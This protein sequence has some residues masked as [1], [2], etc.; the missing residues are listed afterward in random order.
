MAAAARGDLATAQVLCEAGAAINDVDVCA[1]NALFVAA[2]AME[3][4][5]E[6]ERAQHVEVLQYLYK[7]GADPWQETLDGRMAVVPMLRCLHADSHLLQDI[8]SRRDL[9]KM[10]QQHKTLLMLA[11]E[12]GSCA[13]VSSLIARGAD[14]TVASTSLVGYTA[15]H[16]A[17]QSGNVSVV[18]AL[19]AECG[20]ALDVAC[21]EGGR[22]PLHLA[23]ACEG[24]ERMVEVMLEGGFNANACTDQKRTPLHEACARGLVGAAALLLRFGAGQGRDYLGNTPLHF[25]VSM[26]HSAAPEL[27][28]LLLAAREGPDIAMTNAKGETPLISLLCH[29]DKYDMLQQLLDYGTA[30]EDC[31]H[32]V[33]VASPYK[34]PPL[35]LAIT[36]MDTVA[37]HMLLSAGADPNVWHWHTPAL[38]IAVSQTPVQLELT[39]A[40]IAGGASVRH[41][42]GAIARILR[43]TGA[44]SLETMEVLLENGASP[45]EADHEGV[46]PL[47]IACSYDEVEAVRLLLRYGADVRAVTQKGLSAGSMSA[48]PHVSALIAE[49][50]EILMA[51]LGVS[52]ESIPACFAGAHYA[53]LFDLYHSRHVHQRARLCVLG[54]ARCGKTRLVHRILQ[55][56]GAAV[57]PPPRRRRANSASAYAASVSSAAPEQEPIAVHRYLSPRPDSSCLTI[58]DFCASDV[59]YPAYLYLVADCSMCCVVFDVTAKNRMQLLE[60]SLSSI[61]NRLSKQPIIIVG[62]QPEMAGHRRA[63]QMDEGEVLLLHKHVT[64]VGRGGSS[65]SAQSRRLCAAPAKGRSS[66]SGQCGAARLPLRANCR[67]RSCTGRWVRRRYWRSRRGKH[68]SSCCSA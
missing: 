22:T 15:L 2:E 60:N 54:S 8:V 25:A 53:Y 62:S 11:A 4:Q 40:L 6:G 66:C 31:A 33:N 56:G 44:H 1:R 16:Y 7:R 14:P 19:V 63:R 55:L 59:F 43:T 39:K 51:E 24:D 29:P 9:N 20:A 21:A 68:T 12:H 28:R 38:V 58:W 64:E 26:R 46:T 23:V 61:A 57:V 32:H 48:N 27:C 47:H 30:R 49:A 45:N 34:G 36:N 5:R 42:S 18:A 50:A 3:R 37:V 10:V 65:Y 41:H 13:L 67:V 17:V 35:C 52:E